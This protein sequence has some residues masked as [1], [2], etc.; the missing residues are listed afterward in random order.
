MLLSH[1]LEKS[2]PSNRTTNADTPRWW[3]VKVRRCVC[4][5]NDHTRIVLSGVLIVGSADT[6]K[7][8]EEA[9]KLLD[10]TKLEKK[11]EQQVA[12]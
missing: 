7:I 10:A 3:P 6:V 1:E 8:D 9:T 4:S 2:V 11:A 12:L 5:G